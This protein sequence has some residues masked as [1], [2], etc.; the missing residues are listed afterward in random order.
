MDKKD[1]YGSKNYNINLD[2]FKT[3]DSILNKKIEVLKE[4]LSKGFGLF[5][6]R[7]FERFL[8]GHKE[9]DDFADQFVRLNEYYKN[10]NKYS[11]TESS[12]I[13]L[14]GRTIGTEKWRAFCDRVSGSKNPGYAHGGRL[15]P[16]SKKSDHYS[17]EA[18][19][20]AN[21][22]RK[23]N[24][25][26]DYYIEKGYTHSEAEN[27]LKER[28]AVGRL[29]KFQERYGK[30]DG[31]KKWKERQRKWINTMNSKSKEEIDIINRKKSSISN[32]R[33]SEP[34]KLYYIHFFKDGLD[35]WK[36]G[37]TSRDIDKR[38]NFN[39][40][41]DLDGLKWN[42]LFIDEYETAD[43][44]FEREQYVL[45][46][47][48]DYREKIDLNYLKTTEAFSKDVLEGFYQ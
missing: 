18:V 37:I 34:C 8:E 6:R 48:D 12:L 27:F 7:N 2:Q 24:T 35:F 28:Q 38:F 47:F 19:K 45:G 46:V 11:V 3:D 4:D 41:K 21:S 33:K 36:I 44:A 10:H 5:N 25:R 42:I 9:I 40:L 16:W 31:L 15:S 17:E 39:S 20:K 23:Y 22:N 13:L 43:I 1:H 29:S 30:E 26:I 14:Y 32:V